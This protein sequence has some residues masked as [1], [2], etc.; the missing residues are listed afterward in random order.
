MAW[1]VLVVNVHYMKI[2]NFIRKLA[3]AIWVGKIVFFA[4]CVAPLVFRVLERPQAAA[5]QA[6]IFPRY[7]G[8]GLAV[9]S[10][11]TLISMLLAAANRKS[12]CLRW[13]WVVSLAAAGI[14]A[15][16][17][18][19]LTPEILRLQPEVLLLPKGSTEAIAVEFAKIHSLS[20]SLNV[21]ALFLGLV[22]LGLL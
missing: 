9:T 21:G 7:F 6:Q 11:A 13:S 18:F 5:L 3:V 14:Y 20:T 22:C 4:S 17:L 15:Y 16:L 19:V 12:K 1:A 10:I 8:L 2:L